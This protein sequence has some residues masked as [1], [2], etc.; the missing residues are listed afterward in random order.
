M[1]TS[2]KA[3]NA[4]WRQA[5]KARE[6]LLPSSIM[7]TTTAKY[8]ASTAASRA[9]NDAVQIHGANGCGPDYPVQRYFRDARI[10]ELIEGS[11]QMQQVM[12]AQDALNAFA[13]RRRR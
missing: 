4:L 7:E 9:A 12:I 1:T 2:Y 6:E 10:T 13:T 3:A 11:N 8:F 5:A